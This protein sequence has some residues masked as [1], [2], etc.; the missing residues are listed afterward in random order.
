[1]STMFLTCRC[2]SLEEACCIS[3]VTLDAEQST[4]EDML[5]ARDAH[6][7]KPF[8]RQYCTVHP[9][10]CH[11]EQTLPASDCPTISIA[12]P[13]TLRE[14]SGGDRPKVSHLLKM[15]G[16]KLKFLIFLGLTSRIP[17]TV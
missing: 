6:V 14:D 7:Y 13:S 9:G 8:G 5:C 17:Q 2:E 15:F 12:P 16:I 11:S 1:M 3:V 4:T 10:H